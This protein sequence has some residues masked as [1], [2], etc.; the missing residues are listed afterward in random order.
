MKYKTIVIDPPWNISMM[1]K[2]KVRPNQKQKLPYKT[3]TLHEIME[4]PINKFT[5]NQCLLFLWCTDSTIIKAHK[6]LEYWKF[7][8]HCIFVWNKTTGMC[9][10]SVHF[11]NEYCLMGYQGKFKLN[12]IGIRTWFIDTVKNHSEKPDKLY[13]IAKQLGDEPRIDI[14]ARKR[15]DGFDAWGNQVEK[16]IQK[17]LEE[18]SGGIICNK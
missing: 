10:F 13:A 12:K 4:F 7:K 18:K 15:H 6:V 11:C 5:D 9:P 17:K 16:H 14:F 3:M 2:R 8:K 1:N